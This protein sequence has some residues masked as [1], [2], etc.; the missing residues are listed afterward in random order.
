MVSPLIQV[1]VMT[2][3]VSYILAAGPKNFSA[4][5]LCGT[6]PFGFFS[7][8]LMSSF[9]GI[10]AMQPLI[11][12]IYFPREIFV[13]TTV[14]VNFVQM[15]L[16]LFVFLFYRYGILVLVA[17]HWPGWPPREVILLPALML[18]TYLLTLGASLFTSAAF[19]YFED[20]RFLISVFLGLLF[21]M[22]PILYFAEN[23]VYSKKI[24]S[25]AIRWWVYHLYLAN[26][27]A[28]LV[29]AFKQIFFGPQIISK[30][31]A[32]L[33]LS[34]PFDFRY[35]LITCM[36]TLVILFAGYIFFNTMKWKFAE[37]P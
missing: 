33:L 19:F 12:R 14:S 15:V 21:Y 29:T 37:R 18:L 9:T 22:V 10:D 4:Y 8:S 16:S 25:D 2:F 17:G 5:A 11:K 32:P 6:I 26:P 34:A 31:G 7:Q 20:V 23:I 28:W 27:I 35:L 36:S 24:T 1:L 3:A 13:I 30:P